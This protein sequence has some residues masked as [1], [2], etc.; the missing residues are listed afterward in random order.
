MAN[1]PW[2]YSRSARRFR[3]TRSGQFL[4]ATKIIDLRDGFQDRRR[5]TVVALTRQLANE[6]ISVQQWEAEMTQ[7]I[8][9]TFSAQYALGRGGLNSMTDADWLAADDLVQ[10]QRQFLRAFAE[11]IAAGRLSEAQISARAKLYHSASIQAYERGRAAAFG[12]SLP[13]HPA[14]GSTPCKANCVPADT[15]VDAPLLVS[16]YRRWYDGTMVQV[17]TTKGRQLTITPNHPVLTVR[18]WV[19]AGGL[20]VGDD[21]VSGSLGERSALRDPHVQDVPSEISQVFH[22]LRNAGSAGRVMGLPVDFHGDGRDGEVDVVR[23]DGLLLDRLKAVLS[24]PT[25]QFGFIAPD[26]LAAFELLRERLGRFVSG[27]LMPAPDSNM[28]SV[29]EGAALLPRE[30]RQAQ[31]AGLGAS[32]NWH[33]GGDQ[34][35]TNR[36]TANAVALRKAGLTFAGHVAADN[37]IYRKIEVPSR[38]L[39]AQTHTCDPQSLANRR[40][41]D[42]EADAK[43]AYRLSGQIAS[44]KIVGV[45][46]SPFHGY[47]FNLE[48]LPGWY[49]ASGIIVH[50]CKCYWSLVDK[51]E[52]VEATW[53]RTVSESCSVCKDRARRWAPLVISRPSDGRMGRLFRA[54]A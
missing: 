17:R 37:L 38:S 9:E 42:L 14:D 1:S 13:A 50:N 41:L 26:T 12:V 10:A 24:Q 53:K 5:S 3:D 16:A 54:V 31:S 7:A 23:A 2:Q 45:D 36:G 47:V 27:G 6:E 35:S 29:G 43:L 4:S 34:S 32:S 33:T 48:T 30:F 40:A 21:L 8:R 22:A 52:T 39:A 28:G 15:L 18:G 46:I 49:V 11:D 51:G 25:E 19:P 44:D 20:V